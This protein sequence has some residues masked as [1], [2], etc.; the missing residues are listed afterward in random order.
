M[1]V[2]LTIEDFKYLTD[3]LLAKNPELVQ[4]ITQVSINI[5]D[6]D[7]SLDETTADEIRELASEELVFH[8]DENYTPTKEGKMLELFIDKFFTGL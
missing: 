6:I 2:N 8:F 4:N 7:I 1:K 5:N 3:N